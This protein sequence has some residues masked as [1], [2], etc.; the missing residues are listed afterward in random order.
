[1]SLTDPE[2][3]YINKKKKLRKDIRSIVILMAYF[4]SLKTNVNV[5]IV[6][7]KLKKS[8]FLWAFF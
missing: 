2:S 8:V 3:E 5:L 4:L 6:D 1:M 7:K